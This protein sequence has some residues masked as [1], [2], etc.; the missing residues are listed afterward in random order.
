MLLML[1]ANYTCILIKRPPR[2]R[3]ALMSCKK[4][5][6]VE[7]RKNIINQT[8]YPF[9]MKILMMNYSSQRDY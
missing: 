8:K 3:K 4:T 9:Y 5:V 6:L 7:V 2:S 1:S